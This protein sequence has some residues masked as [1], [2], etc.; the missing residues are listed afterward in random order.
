MT[1]DQSILNRLQKNWRIESFDFH[2]RGYWD[3]DD[4][5]EKIFDL[6]N[7]QLRPTGNSFKQDVPYFS[8]RNK[9]HIIQFDNN[10]FYEIEH[11]DDNGLVLTYCVIGEEDELAKVFTIRLRV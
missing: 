8:I 7:I 1:T 9:T 11:L 3:L 5:S 2:L 6:R 10:A 4:S